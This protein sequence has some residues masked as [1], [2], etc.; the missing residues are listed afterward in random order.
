MLI[1]CLHP[2]VSYQLFIT[3][4]PFDKGPSINRMRL[5]RR[6]GVVKKVTKYYKGK[7]CSK[8]WRVL[9]FSSKAQFWSRKAVCNVILTSFC[10][11]LSVQNKLRIYCQPVFKDNMQNNWILFVG[12]K[13]TCGVVERVRGCLKPHHVSSREGGDQKKL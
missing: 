4:I 7:R 8:I 11:G 5:E 10:N 13:I 3:L 12:T 6:S 9:I 2:L 1:D